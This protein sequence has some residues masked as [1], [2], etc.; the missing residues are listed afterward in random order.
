MPSPADLELKTLSP[1]RTSLA[2]SRL[3]PTNTIM[4]T[5]ATTTTAAYNPRVHRNGGTPVVADAGYWHQVQIERLA[6]TA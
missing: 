3:A 2:A 4:L 5:A 1:D 6:A